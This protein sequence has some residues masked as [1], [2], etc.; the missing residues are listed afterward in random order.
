MKKLIFVTLLLLTAG[1][2]AA[3]DSNAW[4]N[5]T[6]SDALI[7]KIQEAQ[8]EYRLCVTVEMQKP[9]Y[10][11]LESKEATGK[12]VKQCEATLAKMRAT[13]LAEKV[14]PVIADR[15][16]KKMRLQTIRNVLQNMMY[17]EAARKAG[18]QK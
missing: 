6:L 17:A 9:A 16:L 10:Q 18:Q 8:A 13:Y 2:Y 14:P 3:E 15:H 1:A 5:T 12:I 11:S 7:K 4:E